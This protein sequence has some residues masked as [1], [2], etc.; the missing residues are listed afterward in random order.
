MMAAALRFI[1]RGLVALGAI[2]LVS[3]VVAPAS[4]SAYVSLGLALWT[5]AL[6]ITLSRTYM[7]RAP[8]PARG[9]LLEYNSHPIAYHAG[10]AVA[11]VIFAFVFVVLMK[12][13]I[14]G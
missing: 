3:A 10:F 2:S 14:S 8:M 4:L 11:V 9:G 7:L 6:L 12:A 1:A 5:L 13:Y